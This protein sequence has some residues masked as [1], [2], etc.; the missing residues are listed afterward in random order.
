[1]VAAQNHVAVSLSELPTPGF[2]V[3]DLRGYYQPRKNLRLTMA[4]ENLFNTYY[5]EPG[6]LAI[7]GPQACPSLCPSRGF[8]VCLV[9]TPAFEP[10]HDLR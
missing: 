10:K 1:M 7:I 8:S 9:S 2:A 4:I 6:S 3:F 5:T